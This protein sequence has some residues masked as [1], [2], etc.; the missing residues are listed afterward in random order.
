MNLPNAD[1]IRTR[2][3]ILASLAVLG[4]LAIFLVQQHFQ[5]LDDRLQQTRYLVKTLQTDM[6]MLRRNEKDF[7]ARRQLKYRDRFNANFR[8]LLDDLGQLQQLLSELGEKPDI[9]SN[10]E[11]IFETYHDSFLQLVALQQ[12]M[13]LDPKSGLTGRL[14]E[15][16][17]QVEGI[18]SKQ[19]QDRLMKDMLMLRR[20]EK[21]FMLRQ[22]LKYRD[23]FDQDLQ[24]FMQDLDASRIDT[25]TRKQIAALMQDYAGAFHTYIAAAE[26][27]GLDSS[28]G[29]HGAMRAAI[30]RSEEAL[31]KLDQQ[32]EEELQQLTAQA[33][34][35]LYGLLGLIIALLTG[36]LAWLIRGIERPIRQLIDWVGALRQSHDLSSRFDAPG[37]DEISQIGQ[38]VNAMI[39]E[40]HGLFGNISTL[41]GEVADTAQELGSIAHRTDTDA[42]RQSEQARTL[43]ERI[44]QISNTLRSMT[45]RMGNSAEAAEQARDVT[46]EGNRIVQSTIATIAQLSDDTENATRSIHQLKED[47]ETVSQVV[48]VITAI[49][50][51]TNLLA[52]NAAIEAARAGEQGRGFAVVADE[53]R[54]LASRTQQSTDEIHQMIERLQRGSEQAVGVMELSR[55]RAGEASTQIRH[56]GEAL[57]S[58]AESVERISRLS[59][60][61]SEAICEESRTAESVADNAEEIRRIA[62]ATANGTRQVMQSGSRLAGVSQQ[63]R[64]GIARFRL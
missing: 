43:L 28:Q 4:L 36:A 11:Q 35:R 64:E 40:F 34:Y 62:E 9:T 23:K 58:I 50:E 27:K 12:R 20:R 47:A 59:R 17:H 21:D 30:H 63:L 3:L 13:G 14:R 52:L 22:Q 44:R 49:A 16:V 57:G 15:A 10:L 46:R 32:I 6:L 45:D 31:Q 54:T 24:L 56:A 37:G 41:A 53:V 51:Q 33:R 26:E 7:L 55:Q 25:E 39:G 1:S 61:T 19:R 38:A 2:L 60:E 5:Q 29:L 8:Q 48:D 42:E 18:V